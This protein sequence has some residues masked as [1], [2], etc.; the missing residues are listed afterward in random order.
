MENIIF[1][2]PSE[3]N[4]VQ[5][6][7]NKIKKASANMTFTSLILFFPSYVCTDNWNNYV[8]FAGYF[9]PPGHWPVNMFKKRRN[10]AT[11]KVFGCILMLKRKQASKII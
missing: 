2:I 8:N 4:A 5:V 1:N 11:F 3:S 10:I 7:I 9:E 6:E